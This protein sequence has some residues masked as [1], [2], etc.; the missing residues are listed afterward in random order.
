MSFHLSAEQISYENE[1][2]ISKNKRHLVRKS[3]GYL[4]QNC[5]QNFNVIKNFSLSVWEEHLSAWNSSLTT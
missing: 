4:K 3:L 5:V 1:F 2:T